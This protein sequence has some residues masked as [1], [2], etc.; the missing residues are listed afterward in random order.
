MT[1]QL[2]GEIRA[3]I[4]KLV[5]IVIE[6]LH[7]FCDQASS[8]LH[9]IGCGVEHSAKWCTSPSKITGAQEIIYKIANQ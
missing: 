5:L 6:Q 8:A 4:N 3:L 1:I 7:Y 2:R 9:R